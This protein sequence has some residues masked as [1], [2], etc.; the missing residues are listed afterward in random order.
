VENKTWLVFFVSLSASL[1][2]IIISILSCPDKWNDFI[3]NYCCCECIKCLKIPKI[4]KK[5]QYP[6]SCPDENSEKQSSQIL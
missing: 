1:F 5:K 3:E 4:M 2:T 6:N